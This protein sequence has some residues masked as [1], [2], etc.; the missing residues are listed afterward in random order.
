MQSNSN[1]YYRVNH[2]Q[3]GSI[4]IYTVSILGIIMSITFALA[5]IFIPKIKT[6]NE[7][8]NFANAVFAADSATEWCLYEARTRIITPLVFSNPNIQSSVFAVNPALGTVTDCDA[9]GDS[10]TFQATGTYQGVSR[11]FEVSQ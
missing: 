10:F 1:F 9:L 11:T 6:V 5:V 4:I 2:M 7:A 3:R 8:V